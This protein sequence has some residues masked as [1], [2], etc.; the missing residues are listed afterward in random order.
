LEKSTT[1]V[2]VVDDY[3]NWHG[4]VSTTLR[5]EPQLEIIGRVFDGLEA[6]RQAEQLQPDLILLDIGLP[7]LNGIEAVRRI[8]EVSP[9]SRTLF[10]SDN[11]SWDIA[12]EA[13]RSGG[14]GYVVKSNAANE[15]LPAVKAVLQGKPF[16]SVGLW[17]RHKKVALSS[18]SQN[19]EIKSPEVTLYPN[20][21]RLVDGFTRSIAA[22]L[23]NGNLTIVIATESQRAQIVQKLSSDGVDVAAA[24]EQKRYVSIGVADQ[25]SSSMVDTLAERHGSTKVVPHAMG[26]ALRTAKEQQLCAAV[27]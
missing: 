3:E 13:L 20:D 2:L 14:D 4:F 11:R 22:A 8:R 24:I 5:K 26:E 12:K 23:K 27:G 19:L 17:G 1:R 25:N 7:G 15:L 21:E 6:V 10:V 9:S 18:T 16:L